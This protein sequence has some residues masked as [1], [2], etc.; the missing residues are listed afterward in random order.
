MATKK[1]KRSKIVCTVCKKTSYFT[2]KTKAV[3]EKLEMM[4][5]C[6]ECK[7]RTTFKEVKR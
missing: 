4:K 1:K 5:F 6:K 3:E 2:N 7:K